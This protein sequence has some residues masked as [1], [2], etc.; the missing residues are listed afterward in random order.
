MQ[1]VH[2]PSAFEQAA[3]SILSEEQL[4]LAQLPQQ[5]VF[6]AEQDARVRTATETKEMKMFFIRYVS[7]TLI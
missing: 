1:A 2:F 7:M 5:E 3:H 6:V 4:S